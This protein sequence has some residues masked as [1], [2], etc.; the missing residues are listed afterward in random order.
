M[1]RWFD[2]AGLSYGVHNS[3][4]NLDGAAPWTLSCWARLETL[5]LGSTHFGFSYSGSYSD[6][7]VIGNNIGGAQSRPSFQYTT[8][9]QSISLAGDSSNIP[10]TEWF[11]LAVSFADGEQILYYNGLPVDSSATAITDFAAYDRTSIGALVRSSAP[12][13]AAVMPGSVAECAAWNCILSSQEIAELAQGQLASEIRSGHL[14]RYFPMVGNQRTEL[15]WR[16]HLEATFGNAATQHR[17]PP[18]QIYP[19]YP[20]RRLELWNIPAA[21]AGGGFQ[22]AWARPRSGFIGHPL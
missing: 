18:A 7:L 4:R 12:H 3:S 8:P 5:G 15:D 6:Y 16:Y 9:T 21:A 17:A 13:V 2:R 20:K 14:Q 10:L 19:A 22:A 1:A 11:H